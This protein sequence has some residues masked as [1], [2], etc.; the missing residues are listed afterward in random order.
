MQKPTL[1]ASL[2]AIDAAFD[3]RH[4]HPVQSLIRHKR[5]AI[6][7]VA[8]IA[9][10]GIPVMAKLRRPVHRAES[11]IMV[12]PT[13]KSLGGDRESF[14]PRYA[15]FVNQ[16]MLLVA[17]EDVSLETLNRLGDRRTLWQRPGESVQDAAIRL[18]ASLR[19]ERVP[20]TS[21][22]AVSLDRG[23][24]EGLL[25][26]VDAVVK[27]YLDRA[28]NESLSG[29]DIRTDALSGRVTQLQEE[30][31]VKTERLSG[32]SKEM[33][34][35]GIE[36]AVLGPI[37]GENDRAH[38][39][40]QERR[41]LAEARLAGLEA[42]YKALML[43]K[44]GGPLV[45][46]AEL[47]QL[48]TVLL[49]RKNELKAKL[50]GLTPAHEGRKAIETELVEIDNE[51]QREEKAA[52]ERQNRTARTKL[53]EAKD[54]ELSAA[55]AEVAEAK[56]Y[57]QVVAQNM[58]TQKEIILRLYPEAQAT[59]QDLERLRG[60]L[61]AVQ[62]RLDGVRLETHAPGYVQ[63]AMPAS[64]SEVSSTSRMI[65]GLF[66]LG[67][68]ALFLA[69]AVPVTLDLTRDRVRGSID[70]EGP[71]ISI[72]MWRGNPERDTAVGDQLRRLAL[73]LDRERR[74]HNRSAFVF[75]SV[76]PGAGTSQLVLDI[77][78][79]LGEFGVSAVAIEANALKPDPR[80]S[81]NGHPGLAT[82]LSGGVRISDMVNPG[83]E[84]FPDRISVGPTEGRTTL[85]GLEKID[86]FLGQALGKYQAVLIDA[87]PILQSAD[88]EYLASRG[89]AVVLVVE[90]ER[91]PLSELDRANRIL[92]QAGTN[93][94]LTVMN[95]VRLWKEQ[96]QP[97]TVAFS[98][99]S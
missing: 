51:L 21:Y 85:T 1:P 16:Q 14:L 82:G 42:K 68:V 39:E 22:F 65:K 19:V 35:P 45:P 67:S 38:R 79:E 87:P 8:G 55:Q 49:A 27:A 76:L 12:S 93:L 2:V 73:A 52:M 24:P 86:S 17:R 77:A 23:S 57:E 37:I 13:A 28:K 43:A 59:Q 5:I 11:M 20:E 36:P 64:L 10:L 33:G 15:E 95:R 61:G 66:L 89:Q 63:L 44:P 54:N 6:A 31:R 88:A 62:E 96:G 30:I 58:A 91:T 25:E 71:V 60:L 41:V 29:V 50:I 74:L 32:L 47:L 18:S 26:I 3:R 9:L 92:R 83:D 46:D 56:R 80:F 34:M 40:A 48:R 70:V 84:R 78:R 98:E 94:V 75:T 81:V 4:V 97:T 7:V 53:E 99:K 72:P 69:F 90:A